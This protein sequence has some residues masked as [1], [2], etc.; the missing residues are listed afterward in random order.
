MNEEAEALEPTTPLFAH[1][2][3]GDIPVPVS[4][5]KPRPI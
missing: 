3:D 4:L 2:L 5:G 1:D